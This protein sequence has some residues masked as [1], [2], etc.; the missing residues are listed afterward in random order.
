M[1]EPGEIASIDRFPVMALV[2]GL[3]GLALIGVGVSQHNLHWYISAVPPLTLAWGLFFFRQPRFAGRLEDDALVLTIPEATI[4]YDTIQSLSLAGRPQEPEQ[5]F[6]WRPIVLVYSGGIVTIPVKLNVRLDTLYRALSSSTMTSGSRDVNGDMREHVAK[7]IAAF[8]EDRVWTFRA[9]SANIGR[10]GNPRQ[11]RCFGLLSLAAVFW[12]VAPFVFFNPAKGN[13]GFVW[14]GFGIMLGFICLLGILT[15]T[16][17]S[18]LLARM[19]PRWRESSLV[20]SPSG[21]AMIQGNM[22]GHMRWDEL[23][24]VRLGNVKPGSFVIADHSGVMPALRLEV[25]GATILIFD[26]YDRPL[27]SIAKFVRQLWRQPA[28]A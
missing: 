3:L 1:D 24:D 6:I 14:L 27:T 23:R 2:S 17:S 8:G 19:V 12:C 28:E 20:I 26:I 18:G 5:E 25:A 9:R 10:V 22:R 16:K 15:A 4:P 21:L 11:L 7:E 13:E